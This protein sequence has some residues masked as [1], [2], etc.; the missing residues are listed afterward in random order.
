[1]IFDG[2]NIRNI[3]GNHSTTQTVL[4]SGSPE[5]DTYH[6]IVQE[7]DNALNCRYVPLSK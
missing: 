5:L 4:P 7:Q 1:M 6:K 3:Q 2:N